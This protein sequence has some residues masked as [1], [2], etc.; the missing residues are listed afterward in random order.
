MATNTDSLVQLIKDL[1]INSQDDTDP[2]NVVL[3]KFLSPNENSNYQEQ[4]TLITWLANAQRAWG[5]NVNGLPV[6]T[7]WN[8]NQNGLW[9]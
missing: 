5:G 8:W 3:Q 1:T 9:G 2:N 4:V 7:N 6:V